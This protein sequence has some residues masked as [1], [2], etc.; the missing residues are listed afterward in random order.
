MDYSSVLKAL[1]DESRWKIVTTLLEHNY[2]V[3]ALA[4]N[5]GI[6][7]SA[8]SQHLKVLREAGLL[9]GTKKGHYMHYEINR[10]LLASFASELLA[11]TG[12]DFKVCTPQPGLCPATDPV[13]C[14][15]SRTESCSDEVK[16]FCH[17]HNLPFDEC[18]DS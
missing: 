3:R 16:H 7:E 1:A 2:C 8:V 4:G 17:G 9:V 10:D 15:E 12:M 5:L 6:T 13:P 14:S 11:L 18:A